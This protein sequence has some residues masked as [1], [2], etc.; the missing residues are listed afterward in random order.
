MVDISPTMG[1]RGT[2]VTGPSKIDPNQI[3]RSITNTLVLLHKTHQ[4]NQA[5]PP[6]MRSL[7]FWV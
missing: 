1:A 3:P 2:T 7:C 5:D 4:G 6:P